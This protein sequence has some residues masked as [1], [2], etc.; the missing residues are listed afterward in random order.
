MKKVEFSTTINAPAE[1]VWQALW[2][3]ANYRNWTSAFSEGSHADTD[4]KEGSKVLFLDGKGSGMFS[5]V[6]KNI[7]NKFMSFKHLGVVKDGVEQPA[8][9]ETEQWAGALEN[10]TLTENNGS[11]KLTVDIDVAGD[12]ETYFNDTFP[13]ALERVKELAEGSTK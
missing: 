13:K 11:T 12:F 8:D 1:Q 2:E 9:A 7:P 5:T 10:Y 6:A 4:W 3:D